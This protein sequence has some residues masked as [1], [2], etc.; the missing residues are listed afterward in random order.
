[1][2]E[3]IEFILLNVSSIRIFIFFFMLI[4]INIWKIYKYFIYFE[5]VWLKPH[6]IKFEKEIIVIFIKFN[7]MET[8]TAIIFHSPTVKEQTDFYLS[9]TIN[10]D[11]QT[12]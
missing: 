10:H 5:C 8:S 12:L 4:N 7:F 2:V 11:C 9:E 3:Y 6:N 1:M